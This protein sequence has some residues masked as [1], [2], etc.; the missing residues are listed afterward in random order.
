METP[1]FGIPERLVRGMNMA[2]QHE[3][4]RTRL[5]R[6][7][8][9]VTAG[10]VA[11]GLLTGCTAATA[12]DRP[13]S[14]ATPA[15]LAPAPATSA[16]SGAAVTPFGRH[17]SFGADPRT[18]MRISW[19]VPAAVH[20]PYVRLGASPDALGQRIEAE[21]RNLHTPG[22]AG[23]RP[24]VE[25]YYVHAALENLLPGT[26]YY[27][28]LGH[29]GLDPAD[30][31]LLAAV[32]SFRTAP[33]RGESFVFTAFGDQ[34]VGD[35]A[36][37]L[38]R[39]LLA[40]QPA[41]HLHAGDICYANANGRGTTADGYDP[42]FWDRF[43]Q[44]NEPVAR[45][46]PWMVTTG[47]HDMEA[48]YSPEG[49]GGQL[50]RFSLPDSGF[51]PRQ[52]PGVYSFVYG[53]VGVVA[54]DANDVSYEIPANLGYSE[55]RQ[56]AWLER[57]LRGLRESEDVDFVVVHFHHCA[58]ST[59]AHAS[60]G[61]VRAA[62]LPLFAQYEAD[63]VINGHNHVYERTDAIRDG[64]VGRRV[65]IGGSTD[66]SRDGTVYVTAGGGG[67]DPYG[68]PVG[69]EDSYEGHV[70]DSESLDTFHWTRS[71]QPQPETVEWSRVRHRGFSFL[72]VEA[73]SGPAPRLKV[74]ARTHTGL[75]IDHFEVRRG[76]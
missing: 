18:T 10:A 76:H 38:D 32:A 69:A 63:L 61:G 2:E 19:Q 39:Q 11:S 43:F 60:D 7:R 64:E 9:L 75:R 27:Y 21:L 23:V 42:L 70:R 24:E 57:T 4:L 37:A 16:A 35:G 66:P 26:T 48:W 73:E 49:Y 28:G 17:L 33:A 74:S 8:T 12:A 41:F 47:N 1:D 72:S 34:G 14:T 51:D 44:Q 46:V 30:P 59:S 20:R 25:Q 36:A 58:Y 71:R 54:L 68:F 29:E 6:R 62:W 40:A 15:S 5:S 67:R 22:V 13:A 52:A 50:A 65:P 31:G 56:T 53:N 55:G 45:S 3:Y